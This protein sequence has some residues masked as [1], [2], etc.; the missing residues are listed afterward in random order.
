MQ[1]IILQVGAL[2]VGAIP[3]AALFIVLVLAYQF[4]VQGPLTETLKKRRA[5]TVGAME[6]AQKA[7]AKAE[8]RTAEYGE[9][10]RLAR[11]DAYKLREQRMKQW[12]AE[13]E[14]IL[15]AARK[16]AAGKVSQARA[17]I[18]AEATSARQAIQSSAADLARQAVRAVLPAAAGG[19]R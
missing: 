16:A 18:D 7:I 14:A 4:L 9:K 2:L 3:T 10:L 12:N 13:R 15:E 19:T 1:D 5:L 8:S 17:E 11:A 6:E